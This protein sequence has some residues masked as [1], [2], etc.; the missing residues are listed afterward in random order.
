MS[1]VSALVAA[2]SA[3]HQRD[4][5]SFAGRQTTQHSSSS[6]RVRLEAMP[7]LTAAEI[8][9]QEKFAELRRKKVHIELLLA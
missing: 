9:L 5:E 3:G 6:H 8:A 1:V 7:K 2:T 4:R